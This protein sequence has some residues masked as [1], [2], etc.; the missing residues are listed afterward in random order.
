MKKLNT[1]ISKI[2]LLTFL[3]CFANTLRAEEDSDKDLA[4]MS[5]EDLL[6]VKI[7]GASHEKREANQ[8]PA[9]VTVIT[10]EEVRLSGARDLKDVLNLVPSISFNAETQGVLGISVRGA[11]GNEGKVL[12]L[13]DG[14]EM[15][16]LSYGTYQ[17]GNDFPVESIARLEVIRGPGS[18]THGGFG[19][20]A[21]INI[22]TKTADDYTGVTASAQYGRT[23]STYGEKTLG[24]GLAGK[25]DGWKLSSYIYG[26]T[27]QF[28]TRDYTDQTGNRYNFSGNALQK[29]AFVN[30]GASNDRW[31]IRFIYDDYSIT[32]RTAY[33]ANITAPL[34][35]LFNS[36]NLGVTYTAPIGDS[37][38]ITPEIHLRRQQPW[39]E[40]ETAAFAVSALNYNTTLEGYTAKITAREQ[41]RSNLNLHFGAEFS[42]VEAFDSAPEPTSNLF[43][44][45][46]QSVSYTH[47][48]VF[49]EL[50]WD[51]DFANFVVGGRYQS[52]NV[53]GS[54]LVPRLAILKEIGNFHAKLLYSWGFRQPQVE[55][56]R[57]MPTLSSETTK[58]YE[59]ELGYRFTPEFQT[60]LNLFT[61]K[62]SQPIIYGYANGTQSYQNS[63]EIR[64]YGLEWDSRFKNKRSM[65][66]INY[67][68]FHP[69]ATP[70]DYQ[71][72]TDS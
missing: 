22:I 27:A 26:G 23:D 34:G 49:S 45:G 65:L 31:N 64:N 39:N 3:L 36:I 8:T 46:L 41:F 43:P 30:L 18:A 62:V 48:A 35:V 58:V 16:E 14:E 61:L 28:G 53:G 63:G 12:V 51:T 9:A 60:T 57:L 42:Q 29:P 33:G 52:Q 21:V 6:K 50:N 17:Y 13:I 32:D 4:N 10:S 70:I 7:Q 47:D 25:K 67:S 59:T 72:P 55:N 19:E 5:L 2:L 38:T 37:F 15:N 24:I 1:M 20:L 69:T 11:Y 40:N 66:D 56:L 44:G 54:A 71:V 68:Y